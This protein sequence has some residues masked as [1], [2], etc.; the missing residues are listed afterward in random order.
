MNQKGLAAAEYHAA[1]PGPDEIL[2]LLKQLHEDD[3]TLVTEII[4]VLVRQR[5]AREGK[6]TG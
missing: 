4:R 3:A 2:V 5:N 1:N 6:T